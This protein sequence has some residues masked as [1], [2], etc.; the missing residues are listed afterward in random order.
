MRDYK[1]KVG[2][3]RCI[4]D[5]AV[6]HFTGSRSGVQEVH[7]ECI[8]HRWNHRWSLRRVVC[9]GQGAPLLK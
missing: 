6:L 9:F 7:H 5:V 4:G 1:G 8:G 3:K 2:Q